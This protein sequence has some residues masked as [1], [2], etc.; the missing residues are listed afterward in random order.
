MRRCAAW[1]VAIPL[2][3]VGSQAAHVFSYRIVYP[4][5]QVRWRVL[6]AT[7]HGYFS[8]WPLVCGVVGGVLLVGFVA[9][10]VSSARRRGPRPLPA[11]AFALLPLV[12]FTVQEFTERWLAGSNFPWW[13]VL[14]PTFRIGLAFQLPFALLAFLLARLLLR[15]AEQVVRALRG[16]TERPKPLA[17]L[18][19]W[20][21][22]TVWPPRVAALADGHAVRGPPLTAAPATVALCRS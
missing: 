21:A 1:L 9:G 8:Y 12:G 14:Q 16:R 3:L 10:M 18:P 13:M 5:E 17:A 19:R 20:F 11:W 4:Q 6:L 7:G 22:L 15:A 2:M